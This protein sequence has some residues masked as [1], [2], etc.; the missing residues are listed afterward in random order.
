VDEWGNGHEEYIEALLE[1]SLARRAAKKRQR[2]P[3]DGAALKSPAM[4]GKA[5][6]TPAKAS[7]PPGRS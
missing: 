3:V 6:K 1:E 7:A 5:S 4:R 2:M